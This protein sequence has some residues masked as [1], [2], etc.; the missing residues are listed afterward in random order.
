MQKQSNFHGRMN[1]LS[2]L[3]AN[4]IYRCL[5]TTENG[6][7]SFQVESMREKYGSNVLS[8]L[9]SDTFLY[10]LFK[11]FI[12]PFSCILLVLAA[13]SFITDVVLQANFSKN[14]ITIVTIITM[15]AISGFIRFMQ[16]SKSKKATEN[17]HN[18]FNRVV[19]VKR[20]GVIIPIH[21]D[22]CVVG[23]LVYLSAGDYV[24]AD[25]RIVEEKNLY[26][27]EASLTGESNTY[28]KISTAID[29]TSNN[30]LSDYE[31][32]AFMSTTVVSG[33]CKGIVLSVGKNTVYGANSV[34]TK[35]WVDGSETE[36]NSISFVFIRFMLVMVS[37]VFV[38]TQI[39]HGNLLSSFLFSLSVAI[40][41]TPELLPLVMT[42]C[43]AKGA[44]TLSKKHTI[45]KNI[46][47]IQGFGRM[48]VLCM[49]KTG[50]ITND[51]I[52]MEYYMDILGNE[53][54]SV[55]DNAYLNSF[56]YSSSYSPID[57]AILSVQ[58]MP[59]K[60]GHFT[61]LINE[62]KKIDDIPFGSER[63]YVS[64]LLSDNNQHSKLIMKGNIEQV[65]AHCSYVEY[66]GDKQQI[67]DNSIENVWSVVNEMLDEGMKVIAVAYKDCDSL[68]KLLPA[69]EEG[70][71][72]I[73]YIAFFDAPKKT[74]KQSIESL[75]KFSVKPK[76]LTGDSL[77]TAKSICKR[78]GIDSNTAITG[79]ELKNLSYDNLCNVVE[80]IDLFAELT[81]QQKVEIITAL[82][83]NGHTVGFLGDGMNDIPAICEA[84]V[85]ISVD[86]AVDTAKD[87]ADVILL[88]KDL[89][90]LTA[91]ILEGRKTF[92]NMLK[93]IKITSSSN[94]GNIISIVAASA[95]L[96]FMPM[97]STQILLLNLLYDLLCIVLPWDKVD[98]EELVAPKGLVAKTL[99]RFMLSFGVISSV[100]DIITYLFL[101]FVLC[102]L[103][104]GGA[105]F[106]D[107]VN[108]AIKQHY[109]SLFQTGWFLESM[110]T[111][112][113]ILYILRTKK[114][115][116]WKSAT[117]K[118]FIFI[119]LLGICSFT[120]FTF[121]DIAKQMGFTALPIYY[122]AFLLIVV[123]LYM[124]TTS[125][126]KR[127][128]IK[129]YDHLI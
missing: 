79:K 29:A 113:M 110:W 49:D 125:T 50:T 15:L 112:V 66:K 115:I 84:D 68:D 104:S 21:V 11:A 111:Q 43:L 31:N 129:K 61:E 73:G 87:I 22:D 101:Y 5:S 14:Y 56:Y 60:S 18:F 122:Y 39:T 95:F 67:A 19:N 44:R 65:L 107:I 53:S 98:I 120:L 93:Y 23:D 17:L 24:P 1:K 2:Q 91:G 127:W 64:V 82:K 7:Y 108:P 96:P 32:I 8:K 3:D 105:L 20:N 106:T 75:K 92:V 103:F 45:V 57:N 26:I 86:T 38:V 123:M 10:R 35:K 41:L 9:K 59:N 28:K 83:K 55:L 27:S 13:I 4:E 85:G 69:D 114:I 71:T 100:F 116:F 46:N 99:P 42:T 109:V 102:P 63:K 30:K 126:V 74:A 119:T 81:P 47:A 54:S 77:M 88:Q 37:I 70:L 118:F 121:T 124:L 40:G 12:N 89:N 6:L 78:V 80:K 72:L 48:D 16:D 36:A 58:S 33:S 94:L 34:H 51:G 97:V 52:L 128:Y 25:L 117:S 76:I 62:F 90:V